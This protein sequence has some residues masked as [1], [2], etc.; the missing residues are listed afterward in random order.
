MR[1]KSADKQKFLFKIFFIFFISFLA[2][3]IFISAMNLPLARDAVSYDA[4]AQNILAGNGFSVD[5]QHPTID[6]KPVYTVFL[7]TIYWIFGHN[8]FLIKIIQ[9]ILIAFTCI[10]VYLIGKETFNDTIGYIS[11]LVTALHP[12]FIAVSSELIAE[13]LF[14]FILSLNIFFL[15]LAIKKESLKYYLYSAILLGLSTQ[16]RMTTVFFPFFIWVGLLLKKSRTIA[17]W[18]PFFISAIMVIL[19]LSPFTLRNFKQFGVFRPLTETGIIWMGS[20]VEGKASQD[21]LATR[22]AVEA[23]VEEEEKQ[24]KDKRIKDQHVADVLVKKGVQNI[25]NDPIG[26]ISLFPHKF[27][28]LWI[29]SYSGFFNIGIPFSDFFHNQGLIK[30][31][32]LI[33]FL[34]TFVLVLS[35]LIFLFAIGGIFLSRQ[36]LMNAAPLLWIII[37]FA[38]LHTLVYSS[39]RLGLPV[40]PYLIIFA[41]VFCHRLNIRLLKRRNQI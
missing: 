27:F 4:I 17:A 9:S 25:I 3:L 35:V 36:E 41:V 18:K 11:S 29:G 24:L 12:V 1:I 10:I 16:V 26:Y 30:K 15:V 23:I 2:Q 7:A 32:P 21:N 39:T 22:R 13:S 33:F 40:V 19:F 14:T 34:K 37:Y 28:R 20:F 8:I 6:V 31:H 38:V 5:G